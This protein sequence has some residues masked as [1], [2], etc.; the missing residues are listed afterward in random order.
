MNDTCNIL[1]D[2]QSYSSAISEFTEKIQD[3]ESKYSAYTTGTQE[4]D[5]T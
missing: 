4:G 5:Q 2:F 1:F 3:L